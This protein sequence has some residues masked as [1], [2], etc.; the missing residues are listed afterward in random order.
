MSTTVVPMDNAREG[1]TIVTHIIPPQTNPAAHIS[2]PLQS[3]LK[4]EPKALGTV[5]IMIAIMTILFAIVIAVT[6]PT[7]YI[8]SGVFFWGSLIL[9]PHISAGS[10][11][12]AAENKLNS[13]AVKGCLTMNIISAV[14][15]GVATVL[16]SVD[17][18]LLTNF[19]YRYENYSK[20]N[21]SEIFYRAMGYLN[22]FRGILL[23]FTV[24]EMIIS[25]CSSAFSCKAI[26]CTQS[27]ANDV[28]EVP[29]PYSQKR[30]QCR[31]MRHL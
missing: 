27:T 7:L 28:V 5:Q 14:T 10:L 11:S 17:I 30:L 13:C 3:F 19:I 8:Y 20:Y 31:K 29:A 22:G 23:V 25:I 24:L 6:G 16:L 21:D 18:G 15:A 9:C 4:G 1:F 26:C 12:V 2:G